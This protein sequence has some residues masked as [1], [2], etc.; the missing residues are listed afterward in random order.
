MEKDGIVE[1]AFEGEVVVGVGG[2]R[3]GAWEFPVDFP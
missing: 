3:H 1:E 2:D